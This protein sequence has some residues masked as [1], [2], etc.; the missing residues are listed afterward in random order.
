MMLNELL[1]PEGSGMQVETAEIE[2]GRLVLNLSS[3][4]TRSVC[5]YCGCESS[6]ISN[7]YYRKPAD[8][9]CAGFAVQL[10]IKVPCFFCDNEACEHSTFAERFPTV[11][12]PYA[13]GTQR[14]ASQ[15]QQVAFES[16]GEAGARLLEAVAMP[17]S[18]DTLLRLVRKAP[19]PAAETPRVLG[20]DDW[21]KKKGQSYGTILV[22]QE[23]HRPVDLLPERSAA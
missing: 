11:V 2:D 1:L 13:R 4:N 15:Q 18:P 8:V 22:D 12:V 20:L 21:A 17:V 23:S 9:P 7:R 6:R 19:E 5:P 14:L 3:T 10:R 16:G